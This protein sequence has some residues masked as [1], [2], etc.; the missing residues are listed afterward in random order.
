VHIFYLLS[1]DKA[2]S[3]LHSM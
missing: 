2:F 3:T 1:V